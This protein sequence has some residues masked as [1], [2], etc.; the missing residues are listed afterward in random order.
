M[1]VISAVLG[2]VVLLVS[3]LSS[4]ECGRLNRDLSTPGSSLT[5]LATSLGWLLSSTF[6]SVFSTLLL[7][8]LLYLD[9]LT[10]TRPTWLILP[11]A[12]LGL[13]PFLQS[14]LY[15]LLVKEGCEHRFAWGIFAAVTPVRFLEAESRKTVVFLVWSQVTWLLS[16]SLAWLTY[17]V[18]SVLTDEADTLFRV[19]L[20]IIMPLLLIP[21]LTAGLLS[22]LEI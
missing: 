16:H 9:S 4:Q 21:P 10:L 1:C 13:A 20:P 3:Y 22:K 6:I 19:W 11:V 7:C 14:L 8:C 2:L 15:H 17:C 5:Y 18:Y 12:V